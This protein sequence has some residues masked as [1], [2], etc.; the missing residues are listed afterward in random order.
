[1]KIHIDL[2]NILNNT[3]TCILNSL[4]FT[5]DYCCGPVFMEREDAIKN[6]EDTDVAG[7]LLVTMV[8]G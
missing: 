5:V 6:K 1:M 2:I 8:I 4:N 7:L 3:C